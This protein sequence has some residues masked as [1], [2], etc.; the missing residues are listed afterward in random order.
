MTGSEKFEREYDRLP[1]KMGCAMKKYDLSDR[2]LKIA[3]ILAIAMIG[4]LCLKGASA[5]HGQT[6]PANFSP[7]MQ[8]LVNHF[9]G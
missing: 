5:A 1:P 8:E 3:V 2:K 9:F 4:W 6:T 7:G